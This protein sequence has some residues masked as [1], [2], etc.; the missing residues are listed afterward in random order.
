MAA[1]ALVGLAGCSDTDLASIDPTITAGSS[2][3]VAI[4]F[5]SYNAQAKTTRAGYDGQIT[6]DILKDKGE[7]KANGFGVFARNSGT[8]T[9]VKS[10]SD[11]T[12]TGS[13][14]PDFMFNQQVKFLTKDD[15]GTTKDY[16]WDYTP[17][18]YWP[19]QIIDANGTKDQYVSFFAYAPYT[20][21]DDYKENTYFFNAKK[22]NNDTFDRGDVKDADEGKKV[23]NDYGILGLA[24][25]ENDGTTESD[26]ANGKIGYDF[27]Q[28]VYDP[29]I[30]YSTTIRKTDEVGTDG[31]SGQ[32]GVITTDGKQVDLLWGTA[33]SNSDPANSTI[34]DVNKGKSYNSSEGDAANGIKVNAD[35]TKMKLD[36]KVEFSFKHALAKFGGREDKTENGKTTYDNAITVDLLNDVTEA[37]ATSADKTVK[38]KNKSLYDSTRVYL[39]YV[40]LQ[41]VDVSGSGESATYSDY[42]TTG[43]FN[44]VTG[45]WLQVPGTSRGTG[46]TGKKAAFSNAVTYL[47]QPKNYSNTDW[48]TNCESSFISDFLG[49]TDISKSTAVL[50]KVE[51]NDSLVTKKTG[52]HIHELG[53]DVYSSTDKYWKTETVTEGGT[54]TKK[55][56]GNLGVTTTPQQVIKNEADPLLVIPGKAPKIRVIVSYDVYTIDSKVPNGYSVNKQRQYE[57]VDFPTL[58]VNKKY[59]LNIHLGLTKIKVNAT[60]QDWEDKTS[61][62][63]G[64]STTSTVN[65]ETVDLPDNVETTTTTPNP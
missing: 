34:T 32:T 39:N 64:G 23:D 58:G 1:L 2:D 5:D 44:L 56:T 47:I 36:G 37:T 15:N 65:V 57:D 40:A 53:E 22:A 17:K 60:V 61:T 11:N 18:K 41:F 50:T 19:N 43:Y 25:R 21:F 29:I 33:G 52:G 59:K 9:Y 27:V 24:F 12:T 3:S 26:A 14:R 31:V 63:S 7:T 54:T 6:E 46:D 16:G 62:T 8:D 38:A 20:E 4:G 13:N 42:P 30:K 49:V 35:L 55:F 51:L 45:R 28:T 10:N 48:N